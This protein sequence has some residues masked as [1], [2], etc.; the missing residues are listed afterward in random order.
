MGDRGV[1]CDRDHLD[2][3]HTQTFN[4]RLEIIDQSEI[5]MYFLSGNFKNIIRISEEYTFYIYRADN[6]KNVKVRKLCR[7]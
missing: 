1:V 7:T 2:T 5:H 4:S 3:T 6:L